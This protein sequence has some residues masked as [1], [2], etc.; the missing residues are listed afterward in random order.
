MA[1][2]S[3]TTATMDLLK[4]EKR[5]QRC[6]DWSERTLA[7][8]AT[9][10]EDSSFSAKRIRV[11]R[12]GRDAE[13]IQTET[14]QDREGVRSEEDGSASQEG[15]SISA[16]GLWCSALAAV[17]PIYGQDLCHFSG[18]DVHAPLL[19]GTHTL[20]VN[21]RAAPPISQFCAQY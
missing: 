10:S 11:S 12:Q 5:V 9:S 16:A 15:D 1:E 8:S 21:V 2:L 4:K 20:L 3:S 19:F 6:I 13:L 7:D 17:M 14:Q 18:D